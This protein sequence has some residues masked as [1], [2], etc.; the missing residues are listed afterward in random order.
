MQT[1]LKCAWCGSDTPETEDT[2]C[3]TFIEAHCGNLNCDCGSESPHDEEFTSEVADQLEIRNSDVK[4]LMAGEVL[5]TGTM[6]ICLKCQDADT[7]G[8]G[9]KNQ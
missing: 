7:E 3:E 6:C 8:E 1:I 5:S 2:M 9:W 4:K